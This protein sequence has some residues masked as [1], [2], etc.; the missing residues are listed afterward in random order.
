LGP[1]IKESREKR[2]GGSQ[3]QNADDLEIVAIVIGT[4]D[5][6]QN[7]QA[8]IER[9]VE[10]GAVV[11][12]SATDA[13][14]HVSVRLTRHVMNEF[15]PVVLERLT[16]PLAAINVGLESFYESL[17]SQGGQAVHVEWRP[18]AGGNEKLAA[19]LQKMKK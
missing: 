4:E 13:I 14:N 15:P 6:P 5:D 7:R 8:Q 9:L 1:I 3:G 10:A 2:S 11:F 18:P 16:Q 19:L 12:S 17:I